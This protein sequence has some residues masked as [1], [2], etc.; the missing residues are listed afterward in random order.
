[1]A[2]STTLASVLLGAL[3]AYALVRLELPGRRKVL[4]LV[5]ALPMFPQMALVGGVHRI[6]RALGLLNTVPGLVLP[7]VSRTLPM[8]IWMLA[9]FFPEIPRDLG[10]AA[11]VDG[12]GPLSALFRV[13][14][15]VAAP[16]VFTTAIL[17]FM[18]A[19]NEF[20]LALLVGVETLPV[21]IAKYPGEHEVPWAEL[22][23][24]AVLATLPLVALVGLLQRRILSG[25]TAG[26][27]KG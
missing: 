6:L 8:G 25:L 17:V 19:W 15:P 22:A 1:M 3:A 10:D 2:G 16:A 4:A 23:A 27:V 11:R 7:Y 13:F 26:A 18:Q 12:C 21:G 14:L 20:F 9:V 24:A 5:L